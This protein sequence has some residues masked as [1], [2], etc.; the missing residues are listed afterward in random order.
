MI[1]KDGRSSIRSC[2]IR[3]QRQEEKECPRIEAEEAEIKNVD[4]PMTKSMWRMMLES[5]N[6]VLGNL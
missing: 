5:T 4:M 6:D 3:L 1:G 2:N